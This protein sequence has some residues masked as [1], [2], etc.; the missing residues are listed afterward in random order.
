MSPVTL[1]AVRLQDL[2]WLVRAGL[3]PELAGEQYSY[4][5]WPLQ[6]MVAPLR[7]LLGPFVPARLVV[8]DGRR[9]G[10]IGR[11]PLS[12]SYEYFL[13][14]WARGGG[15]GRTAI[16]EFLGHHRGGDRTRRLHVKNE[17][18]YRALVGAFEDLGWQEGG[19]FEVRRRRHSWVVTINSQA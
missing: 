18:S 13:Q 14:P 6:P 17:R 8:V 4:W 11:S 2:P 5:E 1:R 3:S 16:A 7:A 10:Y 9:A 12:G 19:Q 15:T